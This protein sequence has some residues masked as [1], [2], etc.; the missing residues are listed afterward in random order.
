MSLEVRQGHKGTSTMRIQNHLG[1][2]FGTYHP[3]TIVPW[4]LILE[5]KCLTDSQ[6]NYA[7]R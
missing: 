6:I 2:V 1:L 4:Y 3:G 7:L 5:K